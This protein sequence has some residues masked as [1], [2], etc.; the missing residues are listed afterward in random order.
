[1]TAKKRTTPLIL[2]SCIDEQGNIPWILKPFQRL[3]AF[4]EMHSE[5]IDWAPAKMDK[6]HRRFAAVQTDSVSFKNT[7]KRLFPDKKVI[8]TSAIIK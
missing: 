6:H 2:V 4:P 1:M 5:Q 3:Q 7:L 8:F